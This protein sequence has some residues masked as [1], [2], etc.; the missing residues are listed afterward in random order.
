MGGGIVLFII[1]KRFSYPYQ[2]SLQQFVEVRYNFAV[3]PADSDLRRCHMHL[4]GS[5]PDFILQNNREWFFFNMS[6]KAQF[7]HE[8]VK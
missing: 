6:E 3:P 5:V 7:T 1:N 4:Y 2:C 8:L